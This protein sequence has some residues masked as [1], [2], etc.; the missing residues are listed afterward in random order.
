M[1]GEGVGRLLQGFEVAL[2]AAR[3]LLFGDGNRRL[4]SVLNLGISP[5]R[6]SMPSIA[7]KRSLNASLV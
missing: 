1:P 6:C 4:F 3:E 5:R 2:V 7:S